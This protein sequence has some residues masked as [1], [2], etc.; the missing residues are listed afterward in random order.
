MLRLYRDV[1]ASLSRHGAEYMLIGGVAAALHGIPRM[2][3]DVD[4]L[5]DPTPENAQRVLDA[6]REAGSETARQIDARELLEFQITIFNDRLRVDV[7]TRAP[8]ITYTSARPNRMTVTY[9][10]LPVY[11]ISRED[12]ILS[13]RAAGRPTDLEDARLLELGEAE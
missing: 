2:S 5:I 6:L 7:L 13:K 1:F 10:G 9:D 8:G 12:F 4:L 3:F 11:L